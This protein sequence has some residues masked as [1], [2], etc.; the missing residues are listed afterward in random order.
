M[1]INQEENMI[2]VKNNLSIIEPKK[3]L[4]LSSK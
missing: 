1:P 2:D 3:F 4:K